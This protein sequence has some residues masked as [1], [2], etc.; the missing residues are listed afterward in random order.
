MKTTKRRKKEIQDHK[1]RV[2]FHSAARIDFI[3]HL[4]CEVTRIQIYG[5]VVNAHTKG[6]GVGR[7]GPYTSIVPLY[8]TVHAHFDEMP[9]DKF[10]DTYGRTK[11]SIK[12]RAPHYEKLW[13]E[14][15]FLSGEDA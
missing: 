9:A 10:F 3:R 2:Q 7:R 13:R 5:E 11:Q 14:R 12:D 1:F 15:G 4:P 8:W 6:G